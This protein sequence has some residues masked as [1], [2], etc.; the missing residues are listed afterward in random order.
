VLG[1][2]VNSEN[3]LWLIREDVR[4]YPSLGMGMG[5]RTAI[6]DPLALFRGR[7]P[8]SN[9]MCVMALDSPC[10]ILDASNPS[11]STVLYLS[12][13]HAALLAS[14]LITSNILAWWSDDYFSWRR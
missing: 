14:F 3:V 7:S 2:F 13:G 9:V 11:F 5:K 8:V 10:P 4:S 6:T 12:N 1:E